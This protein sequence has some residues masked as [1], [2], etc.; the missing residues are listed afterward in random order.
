VFEFGGDIPDIF[1][2]SMD[3]WLVSDMD[4]RMF[5]VQFGNHIM[6]NGMYYG[7]VGPHRNMLIDGSV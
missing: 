3:V 6:M 2:F 7:A 4:R 1:G 5:N